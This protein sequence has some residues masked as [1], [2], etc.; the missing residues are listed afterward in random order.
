LHLL[1]IG[2][3]VK[4]YQRLGI[5]TAGLGFC[6]LGIDLAPAHAILITPLSSEFRLITYSD[7]GGGF[8][9]D[10]DSQS[11]GSTLNPLNASV[12]ALAT[13][14]NASVLTTVKG[15]ATWVNS[16]Q[17]TVNLFDI[18]WDTVGVTFGNALPGAVNGLD[19]AYQFTAG[20]T[21]LFTLKYDIT[22]FGSDATGPNTFGLN[23]F[24]FLWSGSGRN[25]QYLDLNTSGT[26]E[27]IVTAGNTY[28]VTIKNIANIGAG[29]GTRNA[30]MD[31]VFDWSI[32]TS[33][34][35]PEPATIGGI[36]TV[37]FLGLLMK[38]MKRKKASGYR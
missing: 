22:G 28:T 34:T 21:G 15:T 35:I 33:A 38:S 9:T 30:R 1:K 12:S 24:N 18:G 25:Q 31:G 8:V 19:W 23:G 6:L 10:T 20:E 11:Q 36:F 5:S 37:G 3:F 32:N 27:R 16:S 13:F 29:L 7:A 2:G 17:G 14:G 4:L 26:L